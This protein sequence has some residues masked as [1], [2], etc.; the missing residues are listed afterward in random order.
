MLGFG[1]T[2]MLFSAIDRGAKYEDLP[3]I[4][5]RCAKYEDLPS[6]IVRSMPK[7][8]PS[9]RGPQVTLSATESISQQARQKHRLFAVI[10]GFRV[11]A[12]Y[13]W[14]YLK[15]QLVILTLVHAFDQVHQVLG[16]FMR[17]G[18]FLPAYFCST[19]VAVIIRLD[20]HSLFSFDSV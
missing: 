15:V 17:D 11:E 3:S 19:V 4:I 5:V 8:M 20:I 2:E 12:C 18:C 16:V 14:S 10:F 13:Y 1:F 9:T 6:I 7:G